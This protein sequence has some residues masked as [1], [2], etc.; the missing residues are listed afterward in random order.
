MYRRRVAFAEHDGSA[1]DLAKSSDKA[2]RAH[3]ESVKDEISRNPR[4]EFA[5]ASARAAR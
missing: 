3:L 1:S 5:S 4:S 2:T